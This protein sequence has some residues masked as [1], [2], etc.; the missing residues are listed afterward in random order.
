MTTPDHDV[1]SGALT[2]ITR[3][4]ET[5]A[6]DLAALLAE[7]QR[8]RDTIQAAREILADLEPGTPREADMTALAAALGVSGE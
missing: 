7:N 5:L 3:S 2:R 6:A 4:L 1:A 8:L